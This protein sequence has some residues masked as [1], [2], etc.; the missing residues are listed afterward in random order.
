VNWNISLTRNL[1]EK[2]KS[3]K[4]LNL[5]RGYKILFI[6]TESK[7]NSTNLPPPP[8]IPPRQTKSDD[9]TTPPPPSSLLAPVKPVP[10]SSV[11]NNNGNTKKGLPIYSSIPISTNFSIESSN[12]VISNSHHIDDDNDQTLLIQLSPQKTPPS[13]PNG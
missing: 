1:Q 6:E 2:N 10:S 11:G 13:L 5:I 12:G 9:K 7:M 4:I 3:I 8:P